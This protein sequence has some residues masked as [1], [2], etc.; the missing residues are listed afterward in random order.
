MRKIFYL[1]LVLF[2]VSCEKESKFASDTYKYNFVTDDKESESIGRWG[3]YVLT[4]GVMYI[5]N[6]ETG[7]KFKYNHFDSLKKTSSLR[8]GGSYF[9]IEDIELGIT[10]YSFYKPIGNSMNG[11]FLINEDTTKTYYINYTGKYTTVIEDPTSKNQLLGGSAR[12]FQ[13]FINSYQDSL[14]T[15]KINEVECSIGGYNCKVWNNLTFK[16]IQ[17]W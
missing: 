15:I 4:D 9:D 6:N 10:T 8:W 1:F 17:S 14:I 12:P 16:K 2:L 3:K 13:S 11:K 5:Y 7:D